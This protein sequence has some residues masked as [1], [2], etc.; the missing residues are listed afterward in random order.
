M[1]PSR[2][3]VLVQPVTTAD[4]LAGG[5]IILTENTRQAWTGFQAE[6]LAVGEPTRCDDDDCE[7]DHWLTGNQL[8]KIHACFLKP[9]DW[10]LTEPRQ[11]VELADKQWLVPQEAVIARIIEAAPPKTA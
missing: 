2:G 8:H 1:R 3:L 4:T 11:F 6:V 9:G 10:V 7:R 5:R